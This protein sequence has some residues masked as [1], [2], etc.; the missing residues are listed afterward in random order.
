M[1]P[2]LAAE[3]I[4]STVKIR[5]EDIARAKARILEMKNAN[6]D[7]NATDSGRPYFVME[8]VHG[9]PITKYCDDNHLSPREPPEGSIQLCA[10]TTLPIRRH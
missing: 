7:S 3:M 5:R 8:L 4:R 1:T 2:E 9:V 10:I 6:I